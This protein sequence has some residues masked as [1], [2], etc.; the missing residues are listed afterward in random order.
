[1][2]VLKNAYTYAFIEYVYSIY[3]EEVNNH[4][5]PQIYDHFLMYLFRGQ[6]NKIQEYKCKSL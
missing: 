1:M 4:E 3:T 2:W 5:F 6:Q